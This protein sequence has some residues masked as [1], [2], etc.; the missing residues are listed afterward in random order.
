VTK[1]KRSKKKGMI[2]DFVFKDPDKAYVA[3]RLWLPKAL[4]RVGPVKKA[5]EFMV[6][7]QGAQTNHK[8]WTETNNHIVCPREFLR[9]AEYPRYNFPF[10][11][12]RPEFDRAEFEDLVVPRNEEQVKAWF[13]LQANDNGILNLGCG[14]GK[15]KLALKKIAQRQVPTLVVVPDGGILDQ[16]RRSIYGDGETPPGLKFKGKLGLIQGST[17][18]WKHPITLALVTTVALQIRDGKIPEEVFRYFGQIIYDEVHQIGAPV[19]S[20]TAS[21]FYGDR[22]GL[23]ATVQREDGL[24]PIYRYHIGE[25]FY[26][27]LTQDLVPTIYFQQT[28]VKLNDAK[29]QINGMTNISLLRTVLGTDYAANVYRYWCIKKALDDGRKLL[30]LSHSKKQLR[31]FHAMFPGSGLIISETDRD[32]RT[33]VLRKS[34][35]CFAIARLGS[36]GV[37]DDRLD[38]LFW[39]TPFRSKISLQQSMGRIQ[40]SR[41]GKKQPV[42]VVFE[43][44]TSKPLRRL[45]SAIKGT[46]RQWGFKF[47]VFKPIHVP[48]PDYLPPKAQALYDKVNAEI[49]AEEDESE[50]D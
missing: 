38:T 40:R 1:T 34:Q 11:D 32:T 30:C 22:I 16:W 37:D 36:V 13:A 35:I 7:Q 41:E 26:T 44:W 27:D 45:C 42:M 18:D 25:P 8:M 29:T 23:T 46:L 3:N 24:D 50:D 19:F 12:L 31:L 4:I 49:K 39:M 5:L 15:T 20:L 10:I 14:K 43:D 2:L 6:N 17:F 9:S 47:E 48:V 21:P 28:P 33:E